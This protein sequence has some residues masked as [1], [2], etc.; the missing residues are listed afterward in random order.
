MRGDVNVTTKNEALAQLASAAV[1]G[2]APYVP[3]KPL[4]E[5]E[6]EYGVKDS[7]KLASNENPLGPGPKALAA[8]AKASQ[9]LGLYPDGNGFQLKEAIA[10]KMNCSMEQIT[11]GNGSN[12]LLQ[13][14]AEAFLTTDV[15]AV[16]SQYAFAIYGIVVQA[17]GATARVAPAYP[18]NHAMA[19]GHDLDAMR[20][21]VNE[22]TRLVFIANPN[23]P[24]GTWVEREPLRRFIASLPATTIV[25]VDEAY[26][27]YVNDTNY[28]NAALWLNE[29]S[30]L[31]VTRTFSKAHGL[32]GLRVG[33]GLAHPSVADILNRVRQPF[34]VNSLGLVAAAAALEDTDHLARSAQ[35]NREGMQ[36]LRVGLK[37]LGLRCYPSIGNF[38]LV[39]CGRPGVPVYD[40]LLRAGVIVRPVAGYGLPNHLRISIG[41]IAQNQRLLA[42]LAAI[43]GS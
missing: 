31:I 22:R 11:L 34:N 29:F 4:Q 1:R 23:N 19:L 9:E 32:A 33:Y 43:I 16:Y 24:T 35:L 21:L 38:M 42:A 18:D 17:T 26:G 40:S 27:E 30:N 14:A 13:M 37:S 36:Q 41:T 8:I 2:I 12:D 25:L 3:G 39:D 7:I 28:P 6:R 10:K 20:A 15:E 5:L